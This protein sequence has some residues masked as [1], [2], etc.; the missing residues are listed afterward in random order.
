MMERG[1][2]GVL[3]MFVSSTL[4]LVYFAQSLSGYGSVRLT[5]TQY[6]GKRLVQLS[7]EEQN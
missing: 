4:S 5:R 6:F 2:T 7:V 1:F 3:D